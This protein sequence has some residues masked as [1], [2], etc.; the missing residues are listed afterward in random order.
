LYNTG[1]DNSGAV[2]AGGTIG[3]PHYTLTTVP[4]GSALVPGNVEIVTSTTVWG[5]DIAVGYPVTLST[6]PWLGDDSVSAWITPDP[7]GVSPN[8]DSVGAYTYTTSFWM[9]G[10]AE[11]ISGQ[12]SADDTLEDITLNGNLLISFDYGGTHH[13][14]EQFTIPANSDFNLNGENTLGFDV[15]NALAITGLRVE[16][17]AVPD[18]GFT[19]ILLGGALVGLQAF[20]RKLFV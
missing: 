3:D 9:G 11:A 17:E 1:V 16:W 20:R 13:S 4:S 10:N 15:D 5:G 19:V 18:G 8:S 2:L 14:W 12:F 7:A 6:K